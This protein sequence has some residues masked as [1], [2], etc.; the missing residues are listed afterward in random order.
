[1]AALQQSSVASFLRL[2]SLSNTSTLNNNGGPTA[3][4]SISS[5]SS[6]SGLTHVSFT[7]PFTTSPPATSSSSTRPHSEGLSTRPVTGISDNGDRESTPLMSPTRSSDWIANLDSSLAHI[8]SEKKQMEKS[9]SEEGGEAAAAAAKIAYEIL[10]SSQKAAPPTASLESEGKDHLLHS[11]VDTVLS[12]NIIALHRRSASVLMLSTASYCPAG[13]VEIFRPLDQ[14]KVTTTMYN[15]SYEKGLKEWRRCGGVNIGPTRSYKGE[16]AAQEAPLSLKN[17]IL[18]LIATLSLEAYNAFVMVQSDASFTRLVFIDLFGVIVGILQLPNTLDVTCA[19]FDQNRK[20]LLL[21]SRD[22]FVA[23]FAIRWVAYTKSQ[24]ITSPSKKASASLSIQLDNDPQGDKEWIIRGGAFHAIFRHQRPMPQKAGIPIQI[25]VQDL[26]G[27]FL[28]LSKKRSIVCFDVGCLDILWKVNSTC[29]AVTPARLWVDKFGSDFIVLCSDKIQPGSSFSIMLNS[30]HGNRNDQESNDNDNDNSKASS[31]SREILEYWSPPKQYRQCHLNQF[32]RA[33]IPLT[34]PLLS[35][36]MESIG[37]GMGLL[38]ATLTTKRQMQLWRPGGGNGSLCLESTLILNGALGALDDDS[39]ERQTSV[40]RQYMRPPAISFFIK[41][42][43]SPDCPISLFAAHSHSLCVCSLHTPGAEDMIYQREL[44]DVAIETHMKNQM[45]G[46][47]PEPNDY[48]RFFGDYDQS[49]DNDDMGGDFGALLNDDNKEFVDDIEAQIYGELEAVQNKAFADSQQLTPPASA[50]N[51]VDGV[52]PQ[53]GDKTMASLGQAYEK[54]QADDEAQRRQIMSRVYE[55]NEPLPT[56]ARSEVSFIMGVGQHSSIVENLMFIQPEGAQP[57][58]SLL[59]QDHFIPP[60]VPVGTEQGKDGGTRR[61]GGRGRDRD[62]PL[63]KDTTASIIDPQLRL[64]MIRQ[65]IRERIL[66]AIAEKK[67]TMK[68]KANDSQQQ[69]ISSNNEGGFNPVKPLTQY[70]IPLSY[71]SDFDTSTLSPTDPLSVGPYSSDFPRDACIRIVSPPSLIMITAPAPPSQ[72]TEIAKKTGV[73]L[74]NQSMQLITRSGLWKSDNPP[75]E[76]DASTLEF[77]LSAIACRAGTIAVCTTL[78]EAFVFDFKSSGVKKPVRLELNLRPQTVVTSLLAA[79]VFLR[80][81]NENFNP[82][83]K[84]SEPQ[85]VNIIGVHTLTC[86]GDSE[87][88]CNVTITMGS[89]AVQTSHIKAH[90]CA[91]V[92]ILA[93]G[94]AMKPLWR[95]GTEK[96]PKTDQV[97]PVPIPGSG[98]IT[99]A[100]NGEVKVWQP[101]FTSAKNARGKKEV[102]LTINTLTWRLSGIFSA[103]PTVSTSEFQHGHSTAN[104]TRATLDPT[105]TTLLICFSNGSMSLWPIPG[106]IDDGNGSLSTCRDVIH[107]VKRHMHSINDVRIHIHGTETTVKE[108]PMPS[109]ED[110]V[111]VGGIKYAILFFGAQKFTLGYTYNELKSL[112][113]NSSI[114]TSSDDKSI[115]AWRFEVSSFNMQDP[116]SS[117]SSSTCYLQPQPCRRFT[118]STIPQG[119]IC[120]TTSTVTNQPFMILW[121]LCAV[122]GGVVVTAVQDRRNE[123]FT[124]EDD[125]QNSLQE[126]VLLNN[127]LEGGGASFKAIGDKS[128]LGLS[129][130]GPEGD[131]A[132]GNST[133]AVPLMPVL[134]K[135]V[136]PLQTVQAMSKRI[137]ISSGFSWSL[138]QTWAETQELDIAS[139]DDTVNS[140]GKAVVQAS[141]ADTAAVADTAD[142]SVHGI[143]IEVEPQVSSEAFARL[144]NTQDG[145]AKVYFNGVRMTLT[146]SLV[147]ETLEQIRE[148][149]KR[150]FGA[151]GA[152]HSEEFVTNFSR[153]VDRRLTGQA[154]Q[155]PSGDEILK[156]LTS[157]L[158]YGIAPIELS[159]DINDTAD[160]VNLQTGADAVPQD[161]NFPEISQSQFQSSS[162]KNKGKQQAVKVTKSFLLKQEQVSKLKNLGGSDSSKKVVVY[163]SSSHLNKALS[164]N[165]KGV[166]QRSGHA[167]VFAPPT[168]MPLPAKVIVKNVTAVMTDELSVAPANTLTHN[169]SR[170]GI[171]LPDNAGSGDGQ[172]TEAVIEKTETFTEYERYFNRIGKP[173][174]YRKRKP[175][176]KYVSR[177]KQKTDSMFDDDDSVASDVVRPATKEEIAAILTPAEYEMFINDFSAEE[178]AMF[179]ELSE[180]DRNAILEVMRSGDDED[181]ITEI[182]NLSSTSSVKVERKPPSLKSAVKK[183]LTMMKFILQKDVTP[184]VNI[185]LAA[186]ESLNS[187]SITIHSPY[188]G[189]LTILVMREGT[190]VP[191]YNEFSDLTLMADNYPSIVAMKTLS[192]EEESTVPLEIGGLRAGKK[193]RIHYLME[194]WGEYRGKPIVPMTDEHIENTRIEF[195]TH[196]ELLEIEW[197]RLTE[198]MK[199]V[200]VMCA[201]RS[202]AVQRAAKKQVP[203]VALLTDSE[204]LDRFHIT[205]TSGKKAAQKWKDFT[206]WW[207]GEG[208]TFY[209]YTAVRNEFLFSEVLFAAKDE[210]QIQSY[211]DNGYATAEE[212]EKLKELV[213]PVPLDTPN[214]VGGVLDTPIFR[215]FQSWYKAGNTVTDMMD[216]KRAIKAIQ[217]RAHAA[218][219]KVKSSNFRASIK[220][221]F[222]SSF[223]SVNT[224]S[225]FVSRDENII[226]DPLHEGSEAEEKLDAGDSASTVAGKGSMSES[227]GGSRVEFDDE[228]SVTSQESKNKREL[229]KEK[230]PPEVDLCAIRIHDRFE[231]LQS[232]IKVVDY[233][234]SLALK[235]VEAHKMA[236]SKNLTEKDL[237]KRRNQLKVQ[238]VD[239]IMASLKLIELCVEK[240]YTTVK[241]FDV[242]LIDSGKISLQMISNADTWGINNKDAMKPDD[243]PDTEALCLPGTNRRPLKPWQSMSEEEKTLELVLACSLDCVLDQAYECGISVPDPEDWTLDPKVFQARANR[244]KNFAAWYAGEEAVQPMPGGGA[245]TLVRVIVSEEWETEAVNRDAFVLE[246]LRGMTLPKLEAKNTNINRRTIYTKPA[247]PTQMSVDGTDDN[248]S[249]VSETTLGTST[250]VSTETSTVMS[251]TKSL[252][253]SS[254]V[255]PILEPVKKSDLTILYENN[256]SSAIGIHLRFELLRRNV[257]AI[258]TSRRIGMLKL[259]CPPGPFRFSHQFLFSRLGAVIPRLAIP[260]KRYKLWPSVEKRG[261]TTAEILSFYNSVDLDEDDAIMAANEAKAVKLWAYLEWLAL[262]GER[263]KEGRIMMLEEDRLGHVSRTYWAE[264][265]KR[266]Q[267]F[268]PPDET[269]TDFAL[270]VPH[271]LPKSYDY[272]YEDSSS[273]EYGTGI[274]NG[275]EVE[276][277]KQEQIRLAKI[278]LQKEEELKMK[279]QED[280]LRRQ[281]EEDARIKREEQDRRLKEGMERRRLLRDQFDEIRKKRWL[282]AEEIERNRREAER[283]AELELAVLLEKEEAERLKEKIEKQRLLECAT[284]E[285]EEMLQRDNSI[286]KIETRLMEHEDIYSLLHEEYVKRVKIQL[287]ERER[288]LREIYQPFFPFKFKK[289][290]IRNPALHSVLSHDQLDEDFESSEFAVSVEP[291]DSLAL[292]SYGVNALKSSVG[293]FGEDSTPKLPEW[294]STTT[295][296]KFNKWNNSNQEDSE[297][298]PSF[299]DE[300]GIAVPT[301]NS[302]GAGNRPRITLKGVEHDGD[303]FYSKI[304]TTNA[305]LKS[306]PHANATEKGFLMYPGPSSDVKMLNKPIIFNRPRSA[307]PSRSIVWR[308]DR[309]TFVFGPTGSHN[310]G[311]DK[312]DVLRP[313]SANAHLRNKSLRLKKLDP[314]PDTP[315]SLVT[316][317]HS[318]GIDADGKRVGT[319]SFDKF[320]SLLKSKSVTFDSMSL[321]EQTTSMSN[322]LPTNKQMHDGSQMMS[323]SMSMDS[324]L[325]KNQQQQQQNSTDALLSASADLINQLVQRDRLNLLTTQ[326]KLVLASLNSLG[327]IDPLGNTNVTKTTSASVALKKELKKKRVKKNQTVPLDRDGQQRRDLM[328]LAS[329]AAEV[330][331]SFEDKRYMV[332]EFVDSHAV[333]GDNFNLATIQPGIRTNPLIEDSTIAREFR[334]MM[335]AKVILNQLNSRSDADEQ[336]QK[337]EMQGALQD[338]R[339]RQVQERMGAA[340]E[341]SVGLADEGGDSSLLQAPPVF[342]DSLLNES[343]EVLVDKDLQQPTNTQTQPDNAPSDTD[344]G[345]Q[346]N[347]KRQKQK[348]GGS[349]SKHPNQATIGTNKR[350]LDPSNP[351]SS[352]QYREVDEFPPFYAKPFGIKGST[353]DIREVKPAVLE[354]AKTRSKTISNTA[355][356]KTRERLALEKKIQA[357]KRKGADAVHALLDSLKSVPS[358]MNLADVYDDI[359]MS[360]PF[361]LSRISDNSVNASYVDISRADDDDDSLGWTSPSSRKHRAQSPSSGKQEQQKRPSSTKEKD[362]SGNSILSVAGLRVQDGVS[363]SGNFVSSSSSSSSS[364]VRNTRGNS[365]SSKGSSSHGRDASDSPTRQPTATTTATEPRSPRIPT[366]QPSMSRDPTVDRIDGVR[367]DVVIAGVSGGGGGGGGGRGGGDSVLR[368]AKGDSSPGMKLKMKNFE[369]PTLMRLKRTDSNLSEMS[370]ST[371]GTE[372]IDTVASPSGVSKVSIKSS[373]RNIDR[374]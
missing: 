353:V 274:Q 316:P 25:I 303:D 238:E 245:P 370:E 115:L 269:K 181:E 2:S 123:M 113:I 58:Q 149:P 289:E 14:K 309:D 203:P 228:K 74:F 17:M 90:S 106:L 119:G 124:L 194:S 191:T 158:E 265:Q 175:I 301:L 28:V 172:V 279:M 268:D 15:Y 177:R 141:D 312:S 364:R 127:F 10:A 367:I 201:C 327:H 72:S 48:R 308:K 286:R 165:E 202:L 32:Y 59:L 98:L 166:R 206:S 300:I 1:M 23:V 132:D 246:K 61:R 193:Y 60:D 253:S 307:D 82:L 122:V 64:R 65:A 368:D 51:V 196:A 92:A 146:P 150:R 216:E 287:E 89:V 200:E 275:D 35:V 116:K 336:T 261:Y 107:T 183:S 37:L 155:T 110:L 117:K 290:R 240:G 324:L 285:R 63:P 341:S 99:V 84:S 100:R 173:I 76:L 256:I 16:I 78:K 77:K 213:A 11:E 125:L 4:S 250:V 105:G 332:R 281:A 237:H 211:L 139:T 12:T 320:T 282:E 205:T 53:T 178:R 236:V 218:A 182:E 164:D 80:L 340:M 249:V 79:D 83:A 138:L 229:E 198:E 331:S 222:K 94:D 266:L 144:Y 62:R 167:V 49:I 102:V 109:Y 313:H 304:N 70:F 43:N 187:V 259:L 75:D 244:W 306:P 232:R 270:V 333:L 21:G 209:G 3:A 168:S 311:T 163:K 179:A 296:S 137:P 111:K 5:S 299:A 145:L 223:S 231:Y 344:H 328:P 186:E 29:F 366:I 334:L 71:I 363:G 271:A 215:K 135:V 101:V 153:N 129:V 47:P 19:D 73:P 128:L 260:P 318:E 251:M 33:A 293:A 297:Y 371:A 154:P 18:P 159:D 294:G 36:T 356:A 343:T 130:S 85:F 273:F 147:N 207:V 347:Q 210:T 339:D 112:A 288:E 346:K 284:M 41:S 6:S 242:S 361:N 278:A 69:A 52:R 88:N 292:P 142:K 136:K 354:A 42:L 45:K 227:V 151:T 276:D 156:M 91:I 248:S 190:E 199:G 325:L 263:Q 254:T 374:R 351:Y 230:E 212:V 226:H 133:E 310:Q 291:S 176:K 189:S 239:C 359:G 272:L 30:S 302:L 335:D 87:G 220:A 31:K 93:T 241:N 219:M 337:T 161:A 39:P 162:P 326:R 121:K 349:S 295:N 120:Y 221:S 24:K 257:D 233:M 174:I 195:H 280:R 283:I 267:T 319:Y 140:N 362:T 305:Q 40:M 234:K 185:T 143:N 96:I 8:E 352:Y 298:L 315:S 365:S 9:K 118:F 171:V 169:L 95:V 255:E 170:L 317:S 208:D 192:M 235:L 247:M 34:A 56:S 357:A 86:F 258:M 81:P 54:I 97:T 197:G 180:E 322:L 55:Q 13:I 57:E 323:T 22:G 46:A 160:D 20:E 44:L 329:E 360:N 214:Q 131:N 369:N 126:T 348:Q 148:S 350:P 104:V 277:I 152:A 358:N 262:E 103:Q 314:L 38:I 342:Q 50:L 204:I 108:I 345:N 243:P 264:V 68:Q 330:A 157:P 184:S 188:D 67:G 224:K 134:G 66:V 338:E 217:R 26:A 114:V 321:H 7:L 372:D 27:S 373:I 355:A 252:M 225:S